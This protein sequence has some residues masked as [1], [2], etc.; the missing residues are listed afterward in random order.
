MNGAQ[1]ASPSGVGMTSART[2]ARMVERLREQGIRDSAVLDAMAQVP[3]H[4]FVDE[5]MQT[6]AYDDDALP[7]GHGQTISQPYIVARSAELLRAGRIGALGAV[8]EIGSGCGYQSAVLARLA[9]EVLGIERIAALVAKSRR[10]LAT[11]QVR[12]VQIKFADGSKLTEPKGAF[13]AIVF[14]AAASEV[15]TQ[16]LP[17]LA[18][19]GKLVVPVGDSRTQT[20]LE[21]SVSP[22]GEPIVKRLES[23]YFVPVL[24]GLA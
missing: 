22:T 10:N 18:P 21:L 24:G 8:L 12:N 1:S 19:G 9:R 2:R 17:L 5:A 15:P 14:A 11:A 13:D 16:M 23:V 4:V 7:I 6:R 3:R 20:L